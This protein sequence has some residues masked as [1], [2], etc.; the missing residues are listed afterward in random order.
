LRSQPWHTLAIIFI[1]I[2]AGG[3][4]QNCPVRPHNG[5]HGRRVW[6][7]CRYPWADPAPNAG[8]VEPRSSAIIASADRIMA[9]LTNRVLQREPL[10]W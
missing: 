7:H 6:G 5:E 2:L 4:L 10:L 8:L 3:R 9:E 1:L